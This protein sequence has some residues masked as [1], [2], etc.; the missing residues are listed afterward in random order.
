MAHP[1]AHLLALC[2][3]LLPACGPAPP[4]G[5]ASGELNLYNWSDYIAPGTL[6]DFERETGI[7][8][9]YDV[10]DSN[11]L[12]EAKLLAGNTG[13]D[14]VVPSASFVARQITAGVFQPLDRARLSGLENLDPEIM[15]IL[16]TY[17]PG[18]RHAL[19]WLWGTT[20][21][22]Y[23][24]QMIAARLPD[25]PVDSWELVFRP[26]ILARFRDCGVVLL[27]TPSEILPLALNYLGLPPGSQRAED[28]AA[29]EALLGRIRPHVRYFH[30]SQYINDLANGEICL[31]VGWSGDILMARDRA[32][33]AANGHDIAYSLPREGSLVWVDTLAIPRDA[34]HPGNAH[35]FLD[36]ILRPKVAADLSNHVK[37]ANANRAS[38]PLLAAGLR[39]D[40]GIYPPP[41]TLAKL[42][43]NAVN[44]ADYDRLT[45]RAWT[46]L[47]TGH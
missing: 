13:Y 12:L 39:E 2:C 36:Y 23:N 26:E 28:L 3:L 14:L 42:F 5:S 22:G 29:A 17:D 16:A 8:V 4:A 21:I 18:N 33:E 1:R 35:R 11:E 31:V 45:T 32:R 38:L 40:R 9:H 34:P 37:Y 43:P 27:D 7:R 10:F 47:K 41:E 25:A 30:S 15:R 44:G 6:R 20:G 46:R 19:P 24:R